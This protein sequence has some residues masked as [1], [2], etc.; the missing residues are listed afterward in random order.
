MKKLLCIILTFVSYGTVFSQTPALIDK[1]K[2]F[3]LYQTQRYSEA[4]NYLKSIYGKDVTD[5]KAI[6]QIGYCYLMSGNNVEAEQFYTKAYRQEAQN[7]PV[8]FSLASINSRRGNIE[9]AKLYYGEIVKIDS[10]NFSVY[11]QLANLYSSNT[12]SLKLVYLLKANTINPTEG[13]VAYDLADVYATLQQREKA[14]KVL[15]IAMAADTGN[16]IL[17]KAVLPIAN[18]LKKYNEVILSGEKILKVDQDPLVIK[19]VAKAYYFTKNYAKA[20]SLFKMLEAIGLQNEA[21]LYYTSLCYRA[22]KNFPLAK[23]YT[24]KTIDEAISPNT[25]DYYALLGLIYEETD[26][27]PQANKAYKKGLEFKS[28]P[29][30]YYRL[31][32]LYD[33]KYKQPKQAEKYYALYLKSKP[34]PEIDKDEI[35]YVK[36]RMEQLKT[37]D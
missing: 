17:Q 3:D 33:T 28:T 14:Y 6:S 4:A 32:V 30:I 16:I 29:T 1:E 26:K 27:L 34:N 5:I 15:N 19:D 8:L 11:K 24:N 37:A 25:A 23:D 20:A 7:L 35:K 21:T 12:D 2:L 22:M 13:D 9:K 36:A 18:F 31:A 10:N